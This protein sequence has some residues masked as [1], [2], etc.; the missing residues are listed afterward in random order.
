[1]RADIH[2]RF[3]L[4]TIL[5]SD[6]HK[7]QARFDSDLE[8][9]LSFR[10]WLLDNGCRRLA[11]ESTANY[12]QPIYSVVAGDVEFILANT[13]QIKHIPGRKTDALDSEWIA[14]LRLKNLI[15]PS[16]IFSGE[17]RDLR[18]L[19]RTKENFVKMRIQTKNSIHQELE[20]ACIKLSSAI[21]DIFGKS[22]LHII[23][24][25]LKGLSFEEIFDSIPSKR[26]KA[27]KEEI[28]RAIKANISPIQGYLINQ[29]LDSID[30]LN[31]QTNWLIS[32]LRL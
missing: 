18:A 31:R 21:S 10:K 25:I 20:S 19:T 5:S 24:G 13:Y 17:N 16:R 6:G 7:I 4:A 14:E 2:K 22:G 27:K 28:E 15:S 23:K 30:Y 26:L 11:V 9:L 3:L 1:M 32:M 8:G 12:W 29:L